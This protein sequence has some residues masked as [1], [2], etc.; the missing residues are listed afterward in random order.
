MKVLKFIVNVIWPFRFF[1]IGPFA[2]IFI[3][4]LDLS[5]RP[6]LTKLMID[7]VSTKPMSEAYSEM[8]NISIIYIIVLFVVPIGWRIY[9]WCCLKYEPALKTY[10]SKIMIN[11]I[12]AQTHNFFHKNFP[13]SIANKVN[14]TVKYVP[15]LVTLALDSFIMNLVSLFVA[16]Y[17]LWHIH[18]WFAAAMSIWALL[19]IVMSIIVVRKFSDLASMSS[20]ASSKVVGHIVDILSNISTVRL[21]CGKSFEL[22]KLSRVQD[23][24]RK[25]MKRKRIFSLKFYLIQGIVFATYQAISIF[26]LIYLYRISKVTTGDFAMLLS[27]NTSIVVGLSNMTENMRLFSENWGAVDQALKILDAPNTVA[28]VANACPLKVS[29]GKIEFKNVKFHHKG[30]YPLF[31]QLSITIY[32]GEKIGLVGYS[33]SGKTSFVNLIL[34]LYDPNRGSILIDGQ[35]IENVTLDSLRSAIGVISQDTSL[36]H[37]NVLENIRYGKM[38]A[39]DDEVIAAAKKA[40]AHDFIMSLPHG[41]NSNVGEKGVK[42]SAGQKQRIVIARALLKDAPILIFDEATSNLDAITENFIQQ[43]LVDIMNSKTSIVIAHRLS[44]LCSMDRIL[45]FEHGRIVEDGSP[46]DLYEKAGLF[47]D[48]WDAQSLGMLPSKPS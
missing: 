10:I 42:L 28:E 4:S 13:G 46:F 43:N 5:L 15:Q 21:F 3:Y 22:S 39:S 20:E 24:Y 31:N 16:I 1:L 30:D 17:A 29:H 18:I 7:A 37:R 19:F 23:K 45:V 26:M 36:F 8:V 6:Y 41:Y 38:S 34:R 11:K 35:D 33:G 47:R 12:S 44:T 9:D 25:A 32:S 14:D 48:L 40:N 2:M 27:I